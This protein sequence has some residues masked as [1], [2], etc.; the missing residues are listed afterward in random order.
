[1][2]IDI[3]IQLLFL[4]LDGVADPV[5]KNVTNMLSSSGGGGGDDGGGSC[6][7]VGNDEDGSGGGSGGTDGSCDRCDSWSFTSILRLFNWLRN[8][9]AASPLLL[10]VVDDDAPSYCPGIGTRGV[11]PWAL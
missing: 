5:P 2:G 9:A 6:V 11:M 7:D 8:A 1:M 3:M 10:M 4:C